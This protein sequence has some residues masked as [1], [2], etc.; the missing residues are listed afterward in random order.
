MLF[1]TAID[2]P[3]GRQQKRRRGRLAILSGERGNYLILVIESWEGYLFT[4][5][6]L[7]V[8]MSPCGSGD[9]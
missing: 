4:A 5:S 1:L 3:K 7:S 2:I 6:A 8:S 9:G